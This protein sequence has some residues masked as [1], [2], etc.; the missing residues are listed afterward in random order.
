M[1]DSESTEQPILTEFGQRL[2]H[3][4]LER[5]LTQAALSREAGVSKRT[6]ERVES[7]GST[8]LSTLIRILRALGLLGRFENLIPAPLPSPINQLD[9]D[10][11]ERRRASGTRTQAEADS[12]LWTWGDQ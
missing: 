4:R 7:G 12:D 10:E 11:P 6:I 8:Q 9:S 3:R 2:M 1:S 5:N